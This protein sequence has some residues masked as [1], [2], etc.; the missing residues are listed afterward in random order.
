[1]S[2]SFILILNT[3]SS[4]HLQKIPSK[5]RNPKGVVC[6]H[7]FSLSFCEIQNIIVYHMYKQKFVAFF[8]NK[9]GYF[10][11]NLKWRHFAN[12]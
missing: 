6:L 7:F 10:A 4:I 8:T 9:I 12:R 5:S 11:Y 3:G 2:L 1:M